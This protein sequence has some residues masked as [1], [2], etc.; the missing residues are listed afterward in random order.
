M[1]SSVS[2]AT[3]KS[4]IIPVICMISLAGCSGRE[5]VSGF[6][7]TSASAITSPPENMEGI[8][9]QTHLYGTGADPDIITL[10]PETG[11]QPG[12]APYPDKTSMEFELDRGTPVLA[13]LDMILVGFNNRNAEYRTRDGKKDAPYDD[14]EL[15]FESAS[16]DWPGMIIC[17]YHLMDSPLLP[18][19]NRDPEC[20]ASEEWGS[21]VQAQ[22]PQY[23]E[24]DDLIFPETGNAGACAPLIGRLVKRGEVIGYAGNV[25]DH[26]MAPF[27]FKVPDSSNNPTVRWGNRNLHWVQPG[28]FFYWKCYGPDVEFPAG[29]LA[30]PFECG[31]YRLP[32]DQRETTFKYPSAEN[33]AD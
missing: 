22:G 28:S 6:P 27:R 18:G 1:T 2:S 9:T 15:T 26:S 7:E 17:A 16:P 5:S 14:L 29:V 25:G 21:T 11:G 20:G 31:D 32:G 24:R 3:L 10:G 8:N 13:P 19:L 33:T 4:I 30:Y 12:W 23:F